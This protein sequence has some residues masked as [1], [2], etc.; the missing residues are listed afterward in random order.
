[1]TFYKFSTNLFL[2]KGSEFMSAC[3]GISNFFFSEM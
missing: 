2:T 1:M 3:I